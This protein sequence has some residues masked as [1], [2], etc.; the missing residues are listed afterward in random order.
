[1]LN[2]ARIYQPSLESILMDEATL[3]NHREL[4]VEEKEQYPAAELPLL[5]I[6]EQKLYQSLKRNVWGQHVRLEQERI[7]WDAA[8]SVVRGCVG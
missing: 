4:W 6:A 1:M 2:Q 3:L 8:W 7:R 5:D